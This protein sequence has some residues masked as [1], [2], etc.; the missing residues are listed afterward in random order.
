M[1]PIR[2]L[3]NRIRWDRDFGN[4]EFVIGYHDRQRDTIVLVPFSSLIGETDDHFALQLQDPDGM[5]HTVPLHRIR[6]VFRDNQLIWQRPAPPVT[7]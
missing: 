7:R 5:V 4:G 6:Q 1:I 3:L 2:H